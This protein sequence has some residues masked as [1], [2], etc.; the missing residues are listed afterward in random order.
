MMRFDP[1][2][3]AWGQPRQMTVT[4]G[5]DFSPYALRAANNALFAFWSSDRDGNINPYF[6]RLITA[7]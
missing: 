4:A 6:K 3:S 7:L 2:T 1:I 5:D